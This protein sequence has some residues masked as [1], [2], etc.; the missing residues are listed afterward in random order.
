MREGKKDQYDEFLDRALSEARGTPKKISK[1]QLIK[2]HLTI[3]GML[4]KNHRIAVQ[5]LKELFTGE[6]VISKQGEPGYDFSPVG[7]D[8]SFAVVARAASGD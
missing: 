1:S 3:K 2:H 5:K 7:G 4:E 6:Y 8:E